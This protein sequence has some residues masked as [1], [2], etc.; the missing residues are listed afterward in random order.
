MGKSIEIIKS[1]FEPVGD[2]NGKNFLVL[3]LN[4][5]TTF[6]TLAVGLIVAGLRNAGHSVSVFCPLAYDQ[7]AVER[8]YQESIWDDYKRRLNLSSSPYLRAIRD[9]GRAMHGWRLSRLRRNTFEQLAR[10][11]SSRPDAILISAYL[12]HHSTVVKTAAIA[13]EY[14]VPVLLGG[15][16]F[17][18]PKVVE[19]WQNI[20]GV[21][22][23]V[24]GEVDMTI[25]KIAETVCD[26]GDPCQF[27]GVVTSDGRRSR[28]AAPLRPL[29]SIPVPDFSDFPWDRFPS[30]I[31]PM[32]T[33]RGCQWDKCLFCSDVISANGRSFRT[34]SV[35]KVLTEMEELSRRHQSTD[36][37]FLDLKLNSY[38]GM[39]RGI[40]Q[41]I[42]SLVRGAEWVGTV[43]VDLRKDNGLSREDLEIAV[44]GGMRRVSFGLETGSQRLLDLMNKGSSVQANGQFIRDAH[45]TGLSV[46]CTMFAGFPG[47]T[48]EDLYQTLEFLE[49]HH[50]HIDRIRFND[51]SLLEGTPIHDDVVSQRVLGSLTQIKTTKTGIKIKYNNSKLSCANYRRA[52]SSVLSIVHLINR[53]PLR[54]SARNFDGLM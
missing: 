24:G 26:G 47:E 21:T 14:G 23:I 43:H 28:A 13:K 15:P 32:M 50:D 33:G 8:E 54:Q 39:I 53:K 19:A 48:A 44:L 49:N 31:I 37:I 29:D 27:N 20:P 17:N 36:F 41:N 25:A 12:I 9:A 40:A 51:F 4:T 35:E 52:K 30:K 11:I 1:D 18:R 38:P 7:P 16:M 5:S 22:I 6:P 45:T 46:R 2:R 34:K 42:Q 10:R 3:D